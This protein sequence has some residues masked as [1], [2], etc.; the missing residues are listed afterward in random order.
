MSVHTLGEND[1]GL[2]VGP[3]SDKAVGNHFQLNC[4]HSGGNNARSRMETDITRVQVYIH[5]WKGKGQLSE[6]ES[7]SNQ[8][9]HTGEM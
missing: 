9:G 8:G 2:G 4:R 6:L 5:T 3:A 1:A 7:A